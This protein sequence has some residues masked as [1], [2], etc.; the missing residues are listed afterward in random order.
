M[1]SWRTKF[2]C[3]A[4]FYFHSFSLIDTTSDTTIIPVIE[5]VS[6]VQ[7]AQGMRIHVRLVPRVP[8]VNCGGGEDSLDILSVCVELKKQMSSLSNISLFLTHRHHI[9]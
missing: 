8:T 6:D 5:D 9:R 7:T 2:L 3:Y 4:I 1:R